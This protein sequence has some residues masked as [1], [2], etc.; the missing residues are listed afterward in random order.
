MD[1]DEIRK[2][3]PML[4]RYL[5][6][7]EDCFS[8]RDTR[9][10]FST[11]VEGQL[12]DLKEKSCEP[13]QTAPPG[14]RDQRSRLHRARSRQPAGRLR[15]DLRSVGCL[16]AARCALSRLLADWRAGLFLRGAP[17]YGL[18]FALSA[19]DQLPLAGSP[20]VSTG[21]R[22]RS[23]LTTRT[24]T[25]TA[26]RWQIGARPWWTARLLR[27]GRTRP[28]ARRRVRSYNTPQNYNQRDGYQRGLDQ[29]SYNQ[30]GYDER[31]GAY[32]NG[33]Y[34]QPAR[35]YTRP[36]LPTQQAF[37]RPG[38]PSYSRVAPQQNYGY[39]PQTYPNRAQTY[40]VRVGLRAIAVV[41]LRC[42]A[43]LTRGGRRPAVWAARDR[44]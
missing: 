22:T 41:L 33:G 11:Y 2:L 31:G 14:R 7:F 9:E 19:F 3:K 35:G 18:G 26:L 4:T 20:G 27:P 25:H 15:A 24:T 42:D 21:W 17:P 28:H 29:R 12:S 44:K 39:R 34:Q 13:M 37:D 1:A 36:A 40:A 38:Q 8:R 10:H 16:R 32:N 6:R 23:S 5:K 43:P 30:R